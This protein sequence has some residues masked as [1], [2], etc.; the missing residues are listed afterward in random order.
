[1]KII[2]ERTKFSEKRLK[3]KVKGD[4][5]N[6]KKNSLSTTTTSQV[7]GRLVSEGDEPEPLGP[8]V[9]RRVPHYL[10]LNKLINKSTSQQVNKS[11]IE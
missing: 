6:E 10:H 9:R 2:H 8:V 5:A 4:R 7:P 1:M 3:L 11:C